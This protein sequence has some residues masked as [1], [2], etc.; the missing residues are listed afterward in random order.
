MPEGDAFAVLGLAPR[1]FLDADAVR[2][3]HAE[4]IRAA[5]PDTAGGDAAEASRLNE[6]VAVL[7]SDARR[8]QHLLGLQGRTA[9]AVRGVP[10]ELGDFFAALAPDMQRAAELKAGH[11]A[12]ETFLER[13]EFSGRALEVLNALQGHAAVWGRLHAAALGDLQRLDAAW[14]AGERPLAALETCAASLAF[15]EKWRQQLEERQFQL[16]E[17]ATGMG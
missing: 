16:A 12:A 13:A 5:H 3:A 15:L 9:A 10:P 17:I 8:L 6:A 14:Q 4:R 7:Q 2:A 11:A 1:P